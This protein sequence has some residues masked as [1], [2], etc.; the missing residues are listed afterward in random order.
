MTSPPDFYNP[1]RIGTLF[2]PDLGAIAAQA[3]AAG[4]PPAEKDYRRVML[5][6]VDMQVDFCHAQGALYVPGALDDIRRLI[7]FIYRHAER[8]TRITCSLDSHYPFQ[9]FHPAWWMDSAGRHPAPYTIITAED[10][11][12]R[13]WRP[14]LQPDWSHEYVQR[15]QREAKKQLTIWPYH[16]PIGGVG[17]AL[18]PELWSAVF[19]H[20]VARR[21]QPVW[22]TKGGIP[23]TEHYSILKPEIEIADEPQGVLNREFIRSVEQ[24]DALLIAGEAESHCVLETAEDLVEIFRDR[25]DQLAKI[26]ILMD[27]TSPVRHP[28]IDFHAIAQERFKEFA[29]RGVKLIRSTEPF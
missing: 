25:P 7:E 1:A 22:W 3:E 17:N 5:L 12:K 13:R 6:I 8:I 18:D 11:E 27:C 29:A 28:Q 26:R 4:L 20:A 14:V 2:H 24:F 10:V 23:N 9:I 19:W 21:S 16:V 15:L